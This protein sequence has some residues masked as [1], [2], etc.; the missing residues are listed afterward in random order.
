MSAESCV[1]VQQACTFLHR[2]LIVEWLYHSTCRIYHDNHTKC[3][4]VWIGL[5][6]PRHVRS[7]A[8][9]YVLKCVTIHPRVPC[10]TSTNHRTPSMCA[11]VRVRLPPTQSRPSAPSDRP[12]APP[13]R[14]FGLCVGCAWAAIYKKSLPGRAISRLFYVSERAL[15]VAEPSSQS[16][17]KA[18]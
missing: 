1:R 11:V 18:S 14:V 16:K 12:S 3:I 13:D 8:A 17:E 6:T 9:L 10:P 4:H 2:Y 7:L 5:T 15:T